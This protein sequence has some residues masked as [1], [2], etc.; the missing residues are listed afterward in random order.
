ME[1]RASKINHY[2]DD[3]INNAK[4]EYF[5]NQNSENEIDLNI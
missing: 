2:E 3:F 1:N 5:D 4:S